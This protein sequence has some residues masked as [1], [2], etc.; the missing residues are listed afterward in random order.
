MRAK[1]KIC[2][3][4][5]IE[6]AYIVNNFPEIK[7]VGFVFATDSKRYISPFDAIKV[8]KLLRPDIKTVGVF[9]NAN[10][11]AIN[12]I[13]KTVG[14]DVCQLH[15]NESDML[16]SQIEGA[17]VWKSIAVKDRNSIR[18][19]DEYTFADGF[20]LDASSEEAYGGT[21]TKFNWEYAN[22]FSARHFLVLAGGVDK[23]NVAEAVFETNPNVIDLSSSVETDGF[24]DYTKI[25]E[26]VEATRGID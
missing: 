13:V 22:G 12:E 6:D 8:K 14:L 26:F 1:I 3:L 2:G 23:D 16:C 15:S 20:V 25:L 10:V 24:K 17:E 18:L 4:R 5:R 7:Y 9:V 19:A 11:K 21:G